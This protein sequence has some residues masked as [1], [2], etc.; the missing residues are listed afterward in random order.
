MMKELVDNWEY[1]IQQLSKYDVIGVNWRDMPPTSHFCGNF[2]Y[3]STR[4]LRKLADFRFYYDHPRYRVYNP[5]YD[6]RL[7][8][9]FWIGSG[10]VVPQ[11]LSVYC[12]NVDFCNYNYWI[13]K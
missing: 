1:C 3:S 4:Y 6:K 13:N 9:E 12:R 10:S 11:I 8:C 2:W 5:V 7:G